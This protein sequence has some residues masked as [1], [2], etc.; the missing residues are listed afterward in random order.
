MAP[1]LES[2]QSAERASNNH[3]G[4]VPLRFGLRESGHCAEVEPSKRRDIQ[5]GSNE[6][7]IAHPEDPSQSGDLPPAGRGGESMEVQNL[8]HAKSKDRRSHVK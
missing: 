5:I 8:L 2:D 1:E 7:E 3:R 6:L 4:L